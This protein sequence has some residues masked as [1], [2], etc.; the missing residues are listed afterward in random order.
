ME[1]IVVSADGVLLS[2]PEA[3]P[4]QGLWHIPGGTVRFGERLTDAVLRVAR[5]ELGV[6]VADRPIPRYLEYPGY[7]YDGQG[8]PVGVAFMVHL[9]ASSVEGFR[10]KADSAGWFGVSP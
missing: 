3:G 8:W 9:M 6:E 7:L 1:V 4:W 10:P 5:D 2:R